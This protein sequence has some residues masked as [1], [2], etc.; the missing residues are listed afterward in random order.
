MN[1]NINLDKKVNQESITDTSNQ[2]SEI[3]FQHRLHCVT[4]IEQGCSYSQ[5]SKWF[6]EH[7]RTIE[8]WVL[9]AKDCGIE[10][11]KDEQKPG[12]PTK[13]RDDQARA[14]KT[15]LTKLPTE[16]GYK[17]STWNGKL[18]MTHLK[19]KYAVDLGLRQCQRLLNKLKD[20]LIL[21]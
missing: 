10:G 8:R 5:V 9:N 13:I 15:D 19:N 20:E 7:P 11:L 3:R 21:N 12:R 1:R 2:L 17:A 14:L 4:L 6:G 18:L 16:L